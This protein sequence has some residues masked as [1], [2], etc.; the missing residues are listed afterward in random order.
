MA[1]APDQ[2]VPAGGIVTESPV[3]TKSTPFE[4]SSNRLTAMAV[5]HVIDWLM[6]T[7]V[8]VSVPDDSLSTT[9]APASSVR[10]AGIAKEPGPALSATHSTLQPPRST[11][12]PVPLNSS[13][14]SLPPFLISDTTT[15]PTVL[16]PP[17]AQVSL[18]AHGS[19]HPPQW[20]GFSAKSMHAPSHS[21]SPG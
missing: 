2:E 19:L 10:P 4:A 11:A 15:A 16:H 8:A 18:A 21:D 14:V 5:F 3:R 7:V 13:R 6:Y 20:A 9:N 1:L 12:D 17:E